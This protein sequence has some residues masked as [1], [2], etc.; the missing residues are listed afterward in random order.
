MESPSR[1]EENFFLLTQKPK[2][3]W[4]NLEKSVAPWYDTG[5]NEGKDSN[6]EFQKVALRSYEWSTEVFHHLSLY[7]AAGL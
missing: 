7:T 2:F 6:R 3:S 1:T 5:H 4:A